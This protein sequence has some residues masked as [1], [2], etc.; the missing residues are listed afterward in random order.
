VSGGDALREPL[1]VRLAAF[2]ERAFNPI[3]V[4]ELRA[5][6]RGGRF[7]LLHIVL[8]A[9]FGLALLLTAVGMRA[10]GATGGQAGPDPAEVGAGVYFVLQ[11]IQALV[12][13]LVVPGLAATAITSE[14]EGQT[15]E[16]LLTTSMKARQIVWGKFMAALLQILVVLLS[17]LPLVGVCTLFGGVTASQVIANYVVLVLIASLLIVHALAISAGARSAQ[18]AVITAYL[19]PG[20]LG[21]LFFGLAGSLRWSRGTP[22]ELALLLGVLP[23]GARMAGGGG[24]S[25]Y[26]I[27]LYLVALP[28][29]FWLSFFT[30]H[31]VLAVNQLLP[32]HADRSTAPKVHAAFTLLGLWTL[33]ALIGR[34]QNVSA[35]GFVQ[36]GELLYGIVLALLTLPLLLQIFSSEPPALPAPLQAIQDRKRGWRFPLRLFGPG[37]G[38]GVAYALSLVGLLCLLTLGAAAPL[39]Q[40]YGSPQ[41]SWSGRPDVLP[42]ALGLGVVLAWTFFLTTLSRLLVTLFSGRPMPARVLT[43][44][45]S[46]TLA[47][48]PL[49]HWALLMALERD[50]QQAAQA[51]GPW[52]GLLSPILA[53]LSALEPTPGLSARDFPWSAAGLP[54]PLMNLL[55]LTAGGA[56]CWIL[57]TLAR[58][59]FERSLKL[60]PP[61]DRTPA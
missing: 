11:S 49:L 23:E 4:K 37:A 36:R 32:I 3:L 12:V 31:V 19:F 6:F 41:G 2:L 55:I 61:S 7:A 43:L 50:P 26:E 56:T 53:V 8:L 33:G 5:G 30:L 39:T 44:L 48:G 29:F 46:L 57:G 59:V 35:Q 13:F 21:F 16:L 24:M 25:A 54:I 58:P 20:L 52:T 47:F 9:I 1:V 27:G 28:G 40:G 15:L 38:A 45:T 42:L 51:R 14:R 60:E 10:W 18:R 22:M 17:F 34:H